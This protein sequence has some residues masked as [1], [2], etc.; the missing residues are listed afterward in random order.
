MMLKLTVFQ[1]IL[2][3]YLNEMFKKKNVKYRKYPNPSFIEFP[4]SMCFS[5]SFFFF[6]CCSSVLLLCYII[7]PLNL[8]FWNHF[9]G[10][11]I[12]L[13]FVHRKYS[14]WW[15]YNYLVASVVVIVYFHLRQSW[16]YCSIIARHSWDI[17]H[18]ISFV[19]CWGNCIFRR[20]RF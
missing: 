10:S 15:H 18:L 17:Y 11:R 20:T 1:H 12:Y 8:W 16:S 7:A 19:F 13:R 4:P 2:P 5:N 6:F 14:W 9:D 3:Q